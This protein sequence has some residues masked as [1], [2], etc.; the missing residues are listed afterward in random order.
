MTQ[1]AD[2]I[3]FNVKEVEVFSEFKSQL[4]KLK[5]DNSKAVFDYESPRGNK[6]ARSHIYTLRQT[7]GALEKAR[8]EA[9]D[10]ALKYGR[11]VDS[12][13]KEI[14][15]ELDAMI[16]VHEAPL[17]E[18]EEREAARVKAI[19]DRIESMNRHREFDPETTA[20]ELA[21]VLALVE[22]FALDESLEEFKES[23]AVAKDSAITEIKAKL[24]A[25][26]KYEDEQAEL[27]RLRKEQEERAQKEKEDAIAREAVEKAKQEAAEA[28]E[29]KRIVAECAEQEKEHQRQEEAR[30]QELQMERIRRE[31]VEAEKRAIEAERIAKEKAE[32]EQ[33]EKLEAERKESERREANKRHHAKINNQ[34]VSGL[35]KAGLSEQDAKTA[36]EAIAR[37]QVPNVS[38]SY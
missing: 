19:N 27:A 28:E 10:A 8:K 34:A 25:R 24:A 18:I 29:K 17:R 35:V 22:S 30:E 15:E 13:A 33:A 37:K 23:A 7:K 9:K 2:V 14:K 36:V 21:E 20:A 11:L 12:S 16:E 1:Q 31:K 4:A 6:E 5:D 3:P 32:R 26:Q 38:I